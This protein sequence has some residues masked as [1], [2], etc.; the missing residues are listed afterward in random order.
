MSELENMICGLQSDLD[1]KHCVIQSLQIENEQLQVG[2][3]DTNRRSEEISN[4][5]NVLKAELKEKNALL[6]K[7]NS[8]AYTPAEE[9]RID[10]LNEARVDEALKNVKWLEGKLEEKE[11]LLNKITEEQNALQNENQQMKLELC[12]QSKRVDELNKEI[13]CFKTLLEENEQES[14]NKECKIR[15]ELEEANYALNVDHQRLKEY[16][17]QINFLDTAFIF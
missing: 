4:Q 14:Q 2:T 5:L 15:C 12:T 9:T 16:E 17:E 1:Q 13:E 6:D 10:L 7:F 3:I 8:M 11:C